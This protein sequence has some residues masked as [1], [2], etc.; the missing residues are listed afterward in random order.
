MI[1]DEQLKATASLGNKDYAPGDTIQLEAMLQYSGQPVNGATRTVVQVAR[2][3]QDVNDLFSLASPVDP[4]SGFPA[5]KDNDPG[6]S[7]YEA[8]IALSPQFVTALQPVYD[9]I[10]L[11]P[12]S[13][14]KYTAVFS[15]TKESGIYRFLFRLAGS[16]SLAGTYERFILKSAVL[17]FGIADSDKTVFQIVSRADGSYFQLIPKNRFGHLLGPNRLNQIS[18]QVK[19]KF[20]RFT[21]KLDGSY[22][23]PVP[24]FTFLDPD[25]GVVIDIKGDR[26]FDDNY[27]DIDGSDVPFLDK[28]RL[29]ILIFLFLILLIIVFIIWSRRRSAS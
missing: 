13:N 14:G 29:L 9:T 4:P 15:D 19:D 28:Y 16:D 17:D 27:S 6:Q 11:T 26:F 3:G 10:N 12:A 24:E 25:P 22:E 8:L 7:K 2:P 20:L 1:N 23:A 18:L 5:E 21:D